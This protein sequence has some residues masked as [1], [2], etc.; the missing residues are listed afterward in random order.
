MTPEDAAREL[1]ERWYAAW[2]AHDVEAILG[3]VTEDVRYEDPSS[4]EPLMRGR[5][6]VEGSVRAA[7]RAVTDLHL[8]KHEDWVSPGG[9]VI[10][11]WQMAL[12]P[13]RDSRLDRFGYRL[14]SLNAR[15][16][17]RRR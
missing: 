3:L 14:Q 12:L 13:A 16:A 4:A 17:R 9:E 8:E 7:F 1:L 10:A 15:V 2:N 11:S 5:A 6:E